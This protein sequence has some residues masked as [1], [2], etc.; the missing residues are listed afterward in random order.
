MP[1]VLWIA[2]NFLDLKLIRYLVKDLATSSHGNAYPCKIR[3]IPQSQALVGLG[4]TQ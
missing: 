3:H 2:E 1:L 4:G